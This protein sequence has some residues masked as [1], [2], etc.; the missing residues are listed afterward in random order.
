MEYQFQKQIGN[1]MFTF[2]GTAEDHCDFFRQV[3]FYTQLP[4]VGPNGEKDLA[5]LVRRTK[6]KDEYF[7][8]VSK[9]ANKQFL[10]G[11]LKEP[12]GHLFPKHWET[13]QFGGAS[14]DAPGESGFGETGYNP[15][16]KQ[17]SQQT[18]P[19][20][21][22]PETGLGDTP[23]TKVETVKPPV[24]TPPAMVKPPAPPKVTPPA[25][26]G[27]SDEVKSLAKARLNKF[28]NPDKA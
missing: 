17:E 18:P 22:V 8:I 20:D 11:Q 24:A 14:V 3:E 1:T 9:S 10:L 26:A 25:A 4:E 16:D 5:L 15:P 12:K 19:P 27:V 23:A 21:D 6:N 2:R 7:S 13:I 28:L